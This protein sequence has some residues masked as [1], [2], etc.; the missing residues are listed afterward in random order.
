VKAP[1]LLFGATAV[2]MRLY[3]PCVRGYKVTLRRD[4][5]HGRPSADSD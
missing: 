4:Y 5:A 1:F 2:A 3:H